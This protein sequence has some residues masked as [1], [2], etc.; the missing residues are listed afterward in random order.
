MSNSAIIL[1]NAFGLF[2][3]KICINFTQGL[4]DI[5]IEIF[6]SFWFLS[7]IE[8]L[9]SFGL[10]D[11]WLNEF[12]PGIDAIKWF[13]KLC[14]KKIVIKTVAEVT[15]APTEGLRWDSGGRCPLDILLLRLQHLLKLLFGC[16]SLLLYSAIDHLDISLRSGLFLFQRLHPILIR[17]RDLL[18]HLGDAAD[19]LL[20]KCLLDLLCLPFSHQIY[21][22]AAKEVVELA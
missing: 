3:D 7:V 6:S 9:I 4:I 12:Y 22:S 18:F 19:T 10:I 20:L 17:S 2:S 8:L 21:L 15:T 11:A 13:L 14:L 16:L 5:L 1:L